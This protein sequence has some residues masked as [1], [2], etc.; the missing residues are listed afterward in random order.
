LKKTIGAAVI[1]KNHE[2]YIDECIDSLLSQDQKLEHIV[3]CDDASEDNTFS[4]LQ[5]FK[6]YENIS[7][8]RNSSTLGPSLNSNKALSLVKT[9]F[10][11]YTSGDDVSISER[12]KIQQQC[13]KDTGAFCV[14]NDIEIIGNDPKIDENL[15]SNFI[16]SK[17][18][19]I[20][21][22]TELF[23]K[24]NFFNASAACF[25]NILNFENLFN[26]CFIFLQDYD[27]WLRMSIR[28]EIISRPEK[29]LKYRV[30]SSSL[31]QRVNQKLQDKNLMLSELFE[32][33]IQNFQQ[34][35]MKDL[36]HF[37]QEYFLQ[38]SKSYFRP[39]KFEDRKIDLIY[40]LVLSHNNYDLRR[41]AYT[42][43]KKRGDLGNFKKFMSENFRT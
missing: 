7:I 25:T 5:K 36:D 21:L 23:W 28:N 11:M 17:S 41:F 20:D 24:Q 1:T 29:V 32:I 15:I 3:V 34:I 26:P 19:G 40:F 14:I 42:E 31:S 33:L 35:S 6:R 18:V 39:I 37:F 43:M 16:V 38:Y 8:Y 13:L 30:L 12:S 10:I 27:L 4:S 9:D 22:F 2:N